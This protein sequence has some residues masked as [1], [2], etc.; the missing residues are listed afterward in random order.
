MI[1]C[2][3]CSRWERLTF[4][5][6]QQKALSTPDLISQSNCP[7]VCVGCFFFSCLWAKRVSLIFHFAIR[8]VCFFVLLFI[9]IVAATKILST[10]FSHI[11]YICWIQIGTQINWLLRTV[12]EPIT[13]FKCEIRYFYMLL[14]CHDHGNCR[15]L[16]PLKVFSL[17][18]LLLL[19]QLCAFLCW[20]LKINI[21]IQFQYL[22][23]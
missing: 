13:Q 6:R 16:N 5:V 11:F 15:C 20:S 14:W 9:S 22:W 2:A 4:N 23:I 10:L 7:I 8:L 1:S 21:I 3:L 18:F 12:I 19:L 17:V